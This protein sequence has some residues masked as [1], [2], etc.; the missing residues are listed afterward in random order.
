[1]AGPVTHIIFA[2]QILHLLPGNI[3]KQEFIVGTSFPDIR[4]MAQLRREQTHIEPI[5]WNDVVNEPSSFR[6]GMLFHNLVDEV[7]I[8]H[9]EHSFYNRNNTNTLP[10][11]YKKLFC[12]MLKTAED[13]FL[14]NYSNKWHELT[15]YFDIIYQEELD[16]GVPKTVVRT[17]H[18]MIQEYIAQETTTDAIAAFVANNCDIFQ[19]MSMFDPY[20]QFHT[21]MHSALFQNKLHE[22]YNNFPHYAMEFGVAKA[23]CS[24]NVMQDATMFACA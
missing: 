15:S 10:G 23:Q 12:L 11:L 18:T 14:Y 17:W 1:M 19:N 7:R 16:F 13:S 4:Y 2:L 3:D 24:E 9:F 5:S 6:A 8:K 22:F 21:L 20:K